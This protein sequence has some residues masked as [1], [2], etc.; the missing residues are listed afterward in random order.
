M[1][2]DT[3]GSYT[4]SLSD[5]TLT[6]ATTGT[7]TIVAG[8]AT[9]LVLQQS[10]TSGTAGQA[11]SPSVTVA[12][13][14]SFGNVIT[15]DTSTVTVA[16]A[17]GPAGFDAGSTTSM[18]AVGGVATFS[19]L[20][21]DTTGNYTLSVSDGGLT[22]ATTGS[23]T[24][25]PASAS[26]LV[27]EQSPTTGT[28]GQAL[29]PSLTVTVEDS[30]GNVVTSDASTVTVAVATGPA[31][32]AVGSTTNVTPVSGVATFSNLVLD[33]AGNYTLS[34][35]DGGLT[36]VTTGSITISAGL[37]SQ[38]VLQQSPT[39]GTAGQSRR[40]AGGGRRQLRQRNHRRHLDRDGHGCHGTSRLHDRQH[41]QCHGGGR[42]RDTQQFDPRH[43]GQLHAF[44]Q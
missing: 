34:V 29:A 35:S 3:A 8:S 10:P 25:S 17:T 14:D 28:A 19:N 30:F 15:G 4:L 27:L 22:R 24:I 7:I 18:A 42:H 31:G 9:Q 37:A 23:I 43:H 11:L 2:L 41:H 38:L 36:G 40:P 16:V 20:L 13:E 44:S 26:Q 1:I 21:F 32:F 33:T 6:A 39:S 12:V 5:G